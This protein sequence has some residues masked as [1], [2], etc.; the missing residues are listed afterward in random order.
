MNPPLGNRRVHSRPL[1]FSKLR[2]RFTVRIRTAFILTRK[3]LFVNGFP[4]KNSAK[5]QK[6]FGAE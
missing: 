1:A 4:V 2:T 3:G 6:L 5:K